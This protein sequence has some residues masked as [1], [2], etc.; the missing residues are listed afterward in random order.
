MEEDFHQVMNQWMH[1]DINVD[2]PT[3][4]FQFSGVLNDWAGSRFYD[5][6]R[7]IE[8]LRKELNGLLNPIH[9]INN[10]R[11]IQE[12]EHTI[13]RLVVQEETHWKQRARTNWLAQGDGNTKF[14][15]SFASQRKRINHIKGI[16]DE[17]GI[18]FVAEK[19]K[20]DILL[21]FYANLFSSSNPSVLDFEAATLNT[22][23]LVNDAMNAILC[24][25]YTETD[26]YKALFDMQ[27]SKAP[28]P[29]GFTALFFQKNWNIVGKVVVAACLNILNRKG[30]LIGWNET[31]ITLIPKVSNLVTPNDFRPIIIDH[32]QSAFVP[33]RLIT[34][35]VIIGYECMHWIRNNKK[36]KTGFGALKLDM[37]KAYDRVEWK[38]L[39]AMMFKLGF[40]KDFVEL[41]IR[42]ISSVAYSIRINHAMYG[43]I[44]PQR[45]LRQGDPLSP[46]LFAICA[47]G[48]STILSQAEHDKWFQGVNIASQCPSISHLFFADDN[49]IFFRALETECCYIKKCLQIYE[50]ASGQMVNYEKSALTFS[51]SASSITIDAIQRI[52]FISVVKGHELYL[53][54]PTFSLRSKRIQFAGLRERLLKKING[55]ASKFFSAG[56]KETL[57]K[58]VLQAIPSYAMSCFKLPISL[59]NELEQC[60]SNFWWNSKS[61]GGSLHWVRWRNM[62]RPKQFG[63]MGFRSLLA[64]NRALLAKQVWRIINYPSSLMAQV[65]KAR[66]FKYDDIMTAQ[67]G[68]KPSY[69][70][71]SILWSRDLIQKGLLWRVGNG[72]RIKAY[73]DRWIPKLASGMS[74]LGRSNDSLLVHELI[75]PDRTW[76]EIMVRSIFPSFEADRILETPYGILSQKILDIGNGEKMVIIRLN[77]VEFEQFA[78]LAWAIWTD[79]C[80]I[81]HNT[82]ISNI[83]IKV[84]WVFSYLD[85]FQKARLAF[86]AS[87]E[88]S[89]AVSSE[90]WEPPP[91]GDFRLDVDAG[92]K[93]NLGICSVGAV[94]RNQLGMICAASASC[95]RFSG[96]V[97]DAELHAIHFGMLLALKCDFHNVRLFSDSSVA[98]KLVTSL[99]VSLNHQGVLVSNILDLL[100]FGRFY[101]IYHV[102][103]RA[104]RVAHSLA[105]FAF[106]HPSPLCW[107]DALYPSWLMDVAS[108]DLSID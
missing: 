84:N 104:N 19:D 49:L 59:C 61:S 42:C 96:S 71:R 26:I 52:F 55:W 35:N 90:K 53:G 88:I 36:N 99:S 64:F 79:L 17:N 74:S 76:N 10:T 62:C 72:L 51:P 13:E 81:K 106:S 105:H 30:D 8:S 40:A 48:L 32:H 82:Q 12:L 2:L 5:L 83:E 78:L 108:L 34:D 54:L 25:P 102:S 100:D 92:I 58:S 87:S 94:I 68:S 85:Q 86:C 91:I 101:G 41:I 38:F 3:S 80:K 46:Y 31:N 44:I 18:W 89:K 27:P 57:I 16:N 28:G 23:S 103:R 15:H 65:L 66:Y 47:Q 6:S 95:Y 73:S 63:G 98:V 69:V 97:V 39:E 67:L 43:K 9:S 22:N 11:R 24:A 60:C 70:W 14:F 107:V 20:A 75:S 33:G 50:K 29:D 93:E 77:P 7:K 4:L 1:N 37:S 45:G 21:K 56:G